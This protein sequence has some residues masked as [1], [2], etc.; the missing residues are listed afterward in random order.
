MIRRFL[1]RFL[2][3]VGFFSLLILAA[4]GTL[5]WWA[6]GEFERRTQ[7]ELPPEAILVADWRGGVPEKSRGLSGFGP[8]GPL[9]I[10]GKMALPDVLLA[11]DRAARDPRIKGLVVRTDGEGFG[12]GRAQELHAAVRRFADAGKFTAVFADSLG[13]LQGGMVG[14]YLISAFDHVQLQPLGTVALTGLSA[15]QPYFGRLLDDFGIE[16]QI[17][18]RDAYKTALESFDRSTPSPEQA[19]TLA[20]LLD[21]VF[22]QMVEAIAAAR[23]L[24]RTTVQAAIDQG[25]LLGREAL[26]RGLIDEVAHEPELWRLVQA[27]AG[28]VERVGLERFA[29]AVSAEVETPAATIGFVHAVGPIRRGAEERFGGRLEIAGDSLAQA[30]DAAREARVDALLLRVSSPGGSAVASETAAAALR[31]ARAAGIPVVVSMGD[32][33][34]SG[35]YWIAM[36]ADRIVASPM[37]L[38]GSIG[39]VAGKPALGQLLE[40][41]GVDVAVERRGANAGFGSLFEPWDERAL[42]RVNA[43][44]DDIYTSFVE[45]VASARNIDQARVRNLAGGRVW[46]GEEALGNGLIDEAG[47]F[48]EALALARVLAGVAPDDLVTLQRF[49]PPRPPFLHILESFD[50]LTVSLAELQAMLGKLGGQGELRLEAAP[51][52]IR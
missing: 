13:E 40:R 28:T 47:G 3:V 32:V 52:T 42:G 24:D 43:L 9:P 18:Q 36:D 17:V 7:V 27:R 34:A 31:R 48:I 22:E 26:A 33:A 49:P 21:G 16:R 29:R 11:L 39:V 41:W 45:R 10:D 12:L 2:A 38:T 5:V 4:I 8:F 19:E 15:E 50:L 6:L 1:G 46:T 14:T 44:L 23:G 35:G 37:T 25:P 51:P 30:I 20:R